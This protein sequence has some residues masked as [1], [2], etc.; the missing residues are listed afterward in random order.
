MRLRIYSNSAFTWIMLPI[1]LF[2]HVKC[3][4]QMAE[5]ACEGNS[6]SCNLLLREYCKCGAFQDA[7][8]L[9]VKMHRDIYS[10]NFMIS[11]YARL[12]K[13]EEALQ[14]FDQM[15]QE[16]VIPNK[17]IFVSVLS[18]CAIQKSLSRGK[19]IHSRVSGGEFSGDGVVRTALL[20]MYGKCGNLE[21]SR[22]VF[23][24]T[25]VHDVVLWNAM[26]AS[27]SQ[28]G[29]G[30]EALLLFD[31]M[32]Q[33]GVLPSKVTFINVL[34]ACAGEAS[35]ADGKWLHAY[36]V[37]S[38][39]E[40]D[41][42]VGTALVDMY[43]KCS[44]MGNAQDLFARM[45]QRDIVSWNAM[46]AGHAQ[47]GHVE[48]AFQFY[49]QMQHEGVVPNKVTCTS[50]LNASGSQETLSKGKF[51]HARIMGSRF[52][53]DIAVGTALIN[54]YGKCGSINSAQWCFEKM[55]A[56]DV[57]SWNSMIAAFAKHEQG[58]SAL[59]LYNQ[60]E[61]EGFIPN[62][63]TFVSVVSA[64]ACEAELAEGKRVHA[65]I[66]CSGY[67]S[68][69]VIGNVL[70]NMYGKSGSLQNA[71]AVFD[72]MPQ[73]NNITFVN[74]LSICA[75]QAALAEGKRIHALIEGNT[76][77]LDVVVGNTLVNMYSKCG[78]LAD[79][80][81][82][83][84]EM[85]ERNALSWS[86][87]IAAYAQHGEGTEVIFLYAQMHEEG[88]IPDNIT[89]IS[90]LSACSH[91]GLLGEA[92]DCFV[93][94][95]NKH[96][97]P[98]V[99]HYNCMVDLLARLQQLGDAEELINRMPFQ[100]SVVSWTALLSACQNQADVERGERAAGHVL[101]LDPHDATPYITLSNIYAAAGR[102]DDAANVMDSV[103]HKVWKQEVH[104]CRWH[105]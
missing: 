81:R 51:M 5:A 101:E 65:H 50:I 72:S 83:F 67:D 49:D 39:V 93:S 71:L 42:I 22:R 57:T 99:D 58:Q 3:L 75:S 89:Y 84:D 38:G 13:S 47:N 9:F 55:P 10:W 96:C 19:Q 102:A 62:K 105:D 45:P 31:Q 87:I 7:R 91:S 98:T 59:E 28:H 80:Q 6:Y 41:I 46:I 48:E 86:A 25:P 21:N 35:L 66:A 11:A 79:A 34:S 32:Q 77:E 82:I 36:V 8:A 2:G 61:R 74:I 20:N 23:D 90:I 68:D 64:C 44:S 76:F 54:M 17:Y 26:I 27:Y 56:R 29:Q 100:P 95:K 88:I 16:G 33:I 15:Q 24:W 70:V 14:L 94:I 73:W 63:I 43:C 37:E 103:R 85:P 1:P 30:N 92:Y 4:C 97:R 104:N 18:A 69:I 52:E 60:M 53:L 40:S 78:S 12:Q